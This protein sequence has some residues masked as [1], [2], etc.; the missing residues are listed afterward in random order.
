[1]LYDHASDMTR[2]FGRISAEDVNA[3]NMALGIAEPGVRATVKKGDF[4]PGSL[5]RALHLWDQM[6]MSVGTDQIKQFGTE[7]AKTD[8]NLKKW[9]ASHGDDM[10]ATPQHILAYFDGQ[11][12]KIVKELE[13][14]HPTDP[15]GAVLKHKFLGWMNLWR[16]SI[17]LGAFLPRPSHFVNTYFGDMAQLVWGRGF[18]SGLKLTLEGTPAYLGAPGR[19][20]QD[21][22]NPELDP[23]RQPARATSAQSP[24]P[25]RRTSPASGPVPWRPSSTGPGCSTTCR[26]GPGSACPPQ[27]PG[28][29]RSRS[30]TRICTTG[31]TGLL[32]GNCA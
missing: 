9:M 21:A 2:V 29:R 27:S 12:G 19:A 23:P 30:S 13:R 22:L 10:A 15:M 11:A 3:M 28:R 7:L 31:G 25:G 16:R 4:T 26:T 6:G 20:L 18:A 14:M 1:M 32:P 24:G 17:V 5:E 8:A